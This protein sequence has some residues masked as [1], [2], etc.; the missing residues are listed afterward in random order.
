MS[1][2]ESSVVETRAKFNELPSPEYLQ[3]CFEVD[4]E[5]GTLTWRMRPLSHF[6][7][8]VSMRKWNGRYAGERAGGDRGDGYWM[9]GL[10]KECGRQ[11][12]A[13]RI[14]WTMCVGPIPP[15]TRV[16]HESKN[17]SDNSL[18]N[19]RFATNLQNAWNAKEMKVGP[20]K[21]RG[22]P[23][24]VSPNGKKFM[25]KIR[26]NG[27]PTCLGSYETPALA[28]EVYENKRRELAGE[29]YSPVEEPPPQVLLVAAVQQ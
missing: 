1:E 16:D 8:E 2:P 19:L 9:V 10:T 6:P 5:A 4:P 28:S 18:K 12:Y 7:D 21:F 23:R 17:P 24:G 15:K 20:H 25:A 27:K 22:F 14:I 26:I 13:H 29:F 11:V 3:A